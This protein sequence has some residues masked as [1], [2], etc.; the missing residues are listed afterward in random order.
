MKIMVLQQDKG[1]PTVTGRVPDETPPLAGAV[2]TRSKTKQINYNKQ[3]QATTTIPSKMI[4]T[5]S[6][7]RRRN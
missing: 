7:T 6:S 2:V 5:S 4:E 3:N 1:E